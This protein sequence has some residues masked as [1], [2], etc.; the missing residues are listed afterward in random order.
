MIFDST[1]EPPERK[2][3]IRETLSATGG[4]VAVFCLSVIGEGSP[5]GFAKWNRAK[6]FNNADFRGASC[7]AV[8]EAL[9][10]ND[11]KVKIK[12]AGTTVNLQILEVVP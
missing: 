10:E 1:F 9:S 6:V 12:L 5:K 11:L 8:A 4:S 2:V 3:N 7:V